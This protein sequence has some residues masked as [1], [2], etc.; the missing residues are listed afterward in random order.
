MQVCITPIKP[1]SERVTE[2]IDKQMLVYLSALGSLNAMDE[3]IAPKCVPDEEA[4][5]FLSNGP[6]T[7]MDGNNDGE[8]MPAPILGIKI[9]GSVLFALR[10]FRRTS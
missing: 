5:Y 9:L 7:Q 2:S 10:I 1:R 3:P 6:N 8:L 4:V